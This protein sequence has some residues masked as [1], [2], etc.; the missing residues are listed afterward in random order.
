ML[1]SLLDDIGWKENDLARLGLIAGSQAKSRWR[2]LSGN[3]R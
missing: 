3:W 1:K 2:A